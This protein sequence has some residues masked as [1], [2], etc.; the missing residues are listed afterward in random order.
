[1]QSINPLSINS[2]SAPADQAVKPGASW[3]NFGHL[4]TTVAGKPQEIDAHPSRS[5]GRRYKAHPKA[6]ELLAA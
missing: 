2:M 4:F 1:M 5:G 6:G 3:K